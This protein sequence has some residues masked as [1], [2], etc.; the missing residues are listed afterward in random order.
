MVTSPPGP[1]TRGPEV[2]M[3]DIR[4]RVEA[5]PSAP[6]PGLRPL[7]RR[8]RHMPGSNG[9]RCASAPRRWRHAP[10]PALWRGPSAPRGVTRACGRASSIRPGWKLYRDGNRRRRAGCHTRRHIDRGAGAAGGFSSF[11]RSLP[12]PPARPRPARSARASARPKPS[13]H[14]PVT[15]SPGSGRPPG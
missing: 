3:D 14:P 2:D 4:A 8:R 6:R 7:P 9:R 10:M 12:S 13:S 5:E 11:W 1:L 15:G